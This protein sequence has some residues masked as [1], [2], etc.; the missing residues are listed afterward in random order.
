MK[1]DHRHELKTNELAE[2]IANFPQWAKE[3]R[4]TI[5]SVVAIIAVVGGWYV[6]KKYHR[7]VEVRRQTELTSLVSQLLS[8]KMRIVG[9]QAQGRDVSYILLEPANNLEAFAQSVR[10]DQMAAFAL[11]KRAEALRADLH[12]RP[13]TVNQQV[14]IEQINKAKAS[15][16]EAMQRAPSNPS[17][18]AA[19][20]L[21]LGLC[22]EEVGNFE[23]AKQI[24][25]DITNDP[26]FECTV[27]RA[28]A[29]QRLA[30][31]ADYKTKVVF[32]PSPPPK[33]AAAEKPPIEIKP[34]DINLPIDANL[35]PQAPSTIPELPDAN[36]EPN[37]P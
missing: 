25:R 33:P 23:T 9:A 29:E 8:N 4:T 32:K 37:P 13:G 22:E 5:I 6:W 1:S 3:N 14:L 21:G 24:Y 30:T 17:L 11:I 27:T 15:Y 36:L 26:N 18:L 12:Y 28:T 10:N 16:T 31:M 20:K 7:N 34:A 35:G 19:A 2:L